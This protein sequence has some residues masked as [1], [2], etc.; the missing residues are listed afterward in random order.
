MLMLVCLL[1]EN[2]LLLLFVCLSDS[3]SARTVSVGDFNVDRFCIDG[4]RSSSH[5]L[6]CGAADAEI[7]VL[8]A[9]NADYQAFL[10]LSLG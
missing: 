3:V 6:W 9:W 5:A 4:N 7:K 2:D 1:G 8:F 10:L